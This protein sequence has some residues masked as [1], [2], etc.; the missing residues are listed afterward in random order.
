MRESNKIFKNSHHRVYAGDEIYKE[1]EP[2]NLEDDE[3]EEALM[4]LSHNHIDARTL[5]NVSF[6]L[7]KS[8]L[9][10]MMARAKKAT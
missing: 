9:K 3:L 5:F 4:F 8:L 10:K 2:M 6:K 7:R 1:L